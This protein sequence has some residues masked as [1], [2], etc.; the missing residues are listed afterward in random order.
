MPHLVHSAAALSLFLP[1][2]AQAQPE[3][4][5]V[6]LGLQQ[7]GLHEEAVSYFE[8]FLRE[9]QKHE[10]APEAHY[11][12]AISRIELGDADAAADDLRAALKAG[13]DGF[14]LRAECRYRLGGLLEA[15]G[16]HR[17]ACQQFAALAGEVG[18]DHYLLAA[19]RYAEGEAWREL[20]DDARAMA[21][22]EAAIESASGESAAFRFPAL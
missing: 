10:L 15:A 4:W 17:G 11:R 12:L 9:Q 5:Q 14:R 18:R 2:A 8:R 19:A 16:D 1:L 6:A 21:A 7:R 3:A 20:G 13:G 22:F